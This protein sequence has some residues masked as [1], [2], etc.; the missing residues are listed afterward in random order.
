MARP[1]IRFV[2][3]HHYVLPLAALVALITQIGCP[4]MHDE[5]R[6]RRIVKLDQPVTVRLDYVVAEIRGVLPDVRNSPVRSDSGN[7]SPPLYYALQVDDNR[8][9]QIYPGDQP[10][11]LM[12]DRATG[13]DARVGRSV[14]PPTST[15]PADMP[16]FPLGLRRNGYWLQ[17]QGRGPGGA[18]ILE[19]RGSTYRLFDR[20]RSEEAPS[21]QLPELYERWNAR[22]EGPAN[23]AHQ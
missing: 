15:Q 17:A 6:L 7:P 20:T 10:F 16:L 19:Y 2:S 9:L 21:S 5:Y 14:E 3:R 23:D 12:V 18:E 22:K 13:K 8:E 11:A 4:P 1:F